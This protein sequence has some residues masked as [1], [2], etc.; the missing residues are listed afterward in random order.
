MNNNS[1]KKSKLHTCDNE[2]KKEEKEPE[3]ASNEWRLQL[4]PNNEKKDPTNP[5]IFNKHD[6]YA[7]MMSLK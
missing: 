1:K 7:M 5:L 3:T 6:T 2:P 4:K